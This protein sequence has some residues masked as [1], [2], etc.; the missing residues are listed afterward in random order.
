MMFCLLLF[1]ADF[2]HKT[3]QLFR[4][5]TVKMYGKNYLLYWISNGNL[6]LTKVLRLIFRMLNSL[7]AQQAQF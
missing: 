6:V 4:I 1:S 3:V 7:S 5:S 2:V